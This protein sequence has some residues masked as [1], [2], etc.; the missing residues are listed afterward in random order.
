MGLTNN[1][2]DVLHRIKVNLHQNYLPTVDG[3]YLARTENESTL[4]INKICAAMKNRG[5]YAGSY[6]NLVENIR[7]FLDECAYQLCDGY[8][9]NLKYYSIHPNIS[10]TFESERETHNHKKNPINF[11]FRT[12]RPLS[13]LIEHIAVEIMGVSEGNA[14]IDQ[15]IDRDGEAVN[16]TYSAGDMFCITGSKIKVAGDDPNCGL[17]FVAVDDP[18]QAVKV[19]RIG[20][21]TGT[22]VTGITPT[23]SHSRIKLE[24]RTQYSGSTA[25]MLK[26]PRTI[27]SNFTLTKA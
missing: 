14:F 11:K 22:M 13:K 12:L 2:D 7:M 10:G 1:V 8:A 23:T 16:D 9:I 20:E 5:G 3:K 18:T 25:I 26:K 24:I 27:T 17:Y 6:D 4:S 15:Y 19:Q 21:N